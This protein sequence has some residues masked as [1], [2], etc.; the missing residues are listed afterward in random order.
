MLE[1]VLE[2]IAGKDKTFNT[3]GTTSASKY[4]SGITTKAGASG[5]STGTTLASKVISGLE[6]KLKDFLTKGTEAA[7]KY[8]SGLQKADGSGA[9]RQLAQS[10][11]DAIKNVDF[12]RVGLDSADGYVRGLR[13]K[14]EDVARAAAEIG[15]TAKNATKK[16]V[17]S[18][19]PSKEFMKIGGYSGDG[20][21]IGL[22]KKVAD[23]KK[24]GSELGSESMKGLQKSVNTMMQ[25]IDENMDLQPVLSP[26]VD[27]SNLQD[28]TSLIS[29]MFNRSIGVTMDKVAAASS[30]MSRRDMRIRSEQ[31]DR[32]TTSGGNTITYNQYNNSPKALSRIEIYRQTR[33]QLSTLKGVLGSS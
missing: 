19:S 25:F 21:V 17:D 33:N 5:K 26:T 9:G 24:A 28:S 16:A 8:I 14:L 12:Y 10:V 1:A 15:N 4:L 27:L 22:L 2:A 23:A 3:K 32:E 20:Y 7:A 18:N 31:A 6:T 29:E 13:G 11:V 30:S